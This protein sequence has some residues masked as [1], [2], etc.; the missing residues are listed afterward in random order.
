MEFFTFP[1]TLQLIES[2]LVVL[3]ISHFRSYNGQELEPSAAAVHLGQEMQ[4]KNFTVSNMM[5]LES[6]F[7]VWIYIIH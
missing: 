1:G 4:T 3:I 6:I 5:I 7:R 2:F